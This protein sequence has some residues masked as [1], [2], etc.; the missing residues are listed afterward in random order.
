MKGEQKIDYALIVSE[1]SLAYIPTQK[2]HANSWYIFDG[3]MEYAIDVYTASVASLIKNGYLRIQEE[4]IGSFRA[5]GFTI[6]KKINYQI[7]LTKN[8][9][10]EFVVGW[11]EEMIFKRL[12]YSTH[13]YLD[14]IVHDVL[15]E[16]FNEDHHLTNP[17]KVFALEI[18]KHQRINLYE[19]NDESGFFSNSVIVWHNNDSFTHIKPKVITLLDFSSEEINIIKLR[20]IIGAQFRKFRNFD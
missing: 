19:F 15:N 13:N 9:A 14:V 7:Q 12:K 4:E 2:F 8:P 6:W 17:G 1:T 11:V 3:F 18:L 16:I 20:K 5:L 10:E